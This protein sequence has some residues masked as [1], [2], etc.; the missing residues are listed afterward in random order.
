MPSNYV[1][2]VFAVFVHDDECVKSN[3][4]DCSKLSKLILDKILIN[5]FVLNCIL[6]YIGIIIIKV[7]IKY[8]KQF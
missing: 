8:L 6:N 2:I 5:W 3:F 4:I 7:Y 1:F